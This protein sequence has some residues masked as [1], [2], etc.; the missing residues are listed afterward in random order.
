MTK[1]EDLEDKKVPNLWLGIYFCGII[2]LGN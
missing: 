1:K 2:D